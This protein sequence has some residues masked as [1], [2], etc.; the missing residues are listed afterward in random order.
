VVSQYET[1]PL[2][3][4]DARLIRS[5]FPFGQN[6]LSD[7]LDRVL[8][9]HGASKITEAPPEKSLRKA[10]AKRKAMNHTEIVKNYLPLFV[11]AANKWFNER[12]AA[13][14]SPQSW[15]IPPLVYASGEVSQFTIGN[16]DFSIEA[17]SPAYPTV[18]G[19]FLFVSL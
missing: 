11:S 9:L 13:Y 7:N 8:H 3:D 1:L 6:E 16:S 17:F 12:R 14:L 4:T 15:A 18:Q 19:P 10:L 5:W 2:S